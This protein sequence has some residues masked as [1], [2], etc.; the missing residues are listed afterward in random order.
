AADVQALLA[1][2]EDSAGRLMTTDL[3]RVPET[4]SVGDAILA[5]RSHEDVPDPLLA[6]YIVA[7]DDAERLLGLVR[8]RSLLVSP[9]ETPLQTLM[10]DEP[11]TVHPDTPAREAARVLAEYN[12]LAVPVLDDDGCF[13]GIVTVDDALAVLLPEVWQ[14]RR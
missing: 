6:V 1:Y 10:E 2:D 5:I 3:V 11:P 9:P 12:L 13:I 14:R 4:A 8:L 7:D